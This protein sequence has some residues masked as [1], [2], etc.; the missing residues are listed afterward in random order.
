[1]IACA[2]AA[3]QDKA[4][5][6]PPAPIAPAITRAQIEAAL[7]KLRADPNLPGERKTK[8]LR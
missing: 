2:G 8:T 6:P 1:M 3:A 4:P 5:P 7:V